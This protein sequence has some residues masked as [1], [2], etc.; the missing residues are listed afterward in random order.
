MRTS[1][2]GLLLCTL[3]LTGCHGGSRNL[4]GHLRP[5]APGAAQ[6]DVAVLQAS[7][8][9]VRYKAA[10]SGV[11]TA[12]R[13][14]QSLHVA[15]G[16]QTMTNSRA[17]VRFHDEGS[18]VHLGPST[19]L[20]IPGQAPHV[21]RIEHISGRLVARIAGHRGRAQRMEVKLPPGTLVLQEPADPSAGADVEAR[22]EVDA[23]RTRVSMVHGIGHLER[24]QGGPLDVR[25][26]HFVALDAR[27]AVLDEGHEGG[28][29]VLSSPPSGARVRTRSTLLLT[30]Q[31]L[32]GVDA[33]RAEATAEGGQTH[34]VAVDAHATSVRVPIG[35]GTWRWTVR[36]MLGGDPLPAAPAR[37]VTVLIDWTPPRL[38]LTA[39]RPGQVVSSPM[40]IAGVTDPGATVDIDGSPTAIAEDGTFAV[41]KSIDPGL[42]NVVVRATD[43]LGNAR[44]VS[45][46]VLSQ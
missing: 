32:S 8:G 46:S 42:A 22:L 6:G 18:V 36:G 9:D 1:P 11:W 41:R 23:H 20:R 45:R 2:E 15:D 34:V 28:R 7:S 26:A 13:E 10:Q 40:R 4:P 31:P 12:A 39:P 5:V 14:R 30:W 27:G 19:T 38:V 3:M 43:D 25:A 17:T 21:E 37:S 33:Y 16:V 35:A 44:I 29:V 24:H